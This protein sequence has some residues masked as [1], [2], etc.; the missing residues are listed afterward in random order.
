MGDEEEQHYEETCEHRYFP[1]E[2]NVGWLFHSPAGRMEKVTDVDPGNGRLAYAV[3]IFTE[4]TG[5]DYSWRIPRLDKVHALPPHPDG[6]PSAEP[7][8]RIVELRESIIVVPAYRRQEIP[9]FRLALATARFLGPG[10]VWELMD[11][12]AGGEMVTTHHDTKAK[13]RTA[14]MAAARAHAAAL[15]LPIRKEDDRA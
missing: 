5:P 9:A 10:K 14:L 12:P 15:K 8:L 13:A 2:L 4:D 6:H 3:R 11:H 1:W 7:H